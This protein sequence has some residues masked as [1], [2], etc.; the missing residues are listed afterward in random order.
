MTGSPGDMSASVKAIM[1][2]VDRGDGEQALGVARRLIEQAPTDPAAWRALAY[3]QAGRK[4]FDEAEQALRHA[5][6]RA[7]KDALSWEHLGWMYRRSGDF[8]RAVTALQESLAIDASKPRPRMMLANSLADL[9]KTKR[10]IAATSPI[11]SAKR[12]RCR[13]RTPACSCRWEM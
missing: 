11:R 7:P 9:G 5:I 3:V 2:M 10:A 1:A 4:A 13:P 6:S 12:D 8:A